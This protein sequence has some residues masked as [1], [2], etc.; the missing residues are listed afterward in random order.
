MVAGPSEAAVQA[1]AK[2]AA[3]PAMAAEAAP[4]VATVAAVAKAAPTVAAV[5]KAAAVGPSTNSGQD[6]CCPRC[7][8]RRT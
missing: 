3:L 2:V 8:K 4:T 1:A 6:C 7:M 5:A